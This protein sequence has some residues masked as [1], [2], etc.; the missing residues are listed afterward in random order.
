MAPSQAELRDR[1]HR[2]WQEAEPTS[3]AQCLANIKVSRRGLDPPIRLCGPT[4]DQVVG[5]RLFWDE[6]HHGYDT[7]QQLGTGY[8][9]T[10]GASQILM[11]YYDPTY[12]Q[13]GPQ[14]RVTFRNN[15]F[16]ANKQ[17]LPMNVRLSD[18][19]LGALFMSKTPAAVLHANFPFDFAA[20]GFP[21]PSRLGVGDPFRPR[22]LCQDYQTDN[23][24]KLDH[25]IAYIIVPALP[26]EL[27]ILGGDHLRSATNGDIFQ[28]WDK[29]FVQI[30]RRNA[31]GGS[32]KSL[33]PYRSMSTPKPHRSSKAVPNLNTNTTEL[34][35][36]NP[37]PQALTLNIPSSS[38]LLAD[39][40]A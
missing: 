8:A 10:S 38:G 16:Y 4:T 5:E 9:I 26:R 20:D 36:P 34:P 40:F 25:R 14:F 11:P 27:I 1:V 3:L 24:L 13:L 30:T 6:K 2:Q 19:L 37:N 29:T 7:R 17:R 22:H 31:T 21:Y 39:L 28:E 35:I 15:N 12:E 33:Q 32:W 18:I 23:D